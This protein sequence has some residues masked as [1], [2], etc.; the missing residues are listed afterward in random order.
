MKPLLIAAALLFAAPVA[1][2]P[3]AA[4]LFAAGKFSDAVTA[5]IAE[6]TPAS[7]VIAG[8]SQLQIAAYQTTDKAKARTLIA[9]ANTN[10][11]AALAKAPG[12]IDATLQ[13]IVAQGYVAK[14][15]QSS[16]GAKAMKK[17]LDAFLA[18]HPDNA[19]AWAVLGGWNGGAVASVG[20]FIAGTVLGAKL[21]NMTNAFDR[22]MALA[23]TDPAHPTFYALTLLDIDDDNA[24]QAKALL[25]R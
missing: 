5:G 19:V 2:A 21:G 9:A 25:T 22:A 15:D 13:K 14:L 24:A 16:G 23:P 17:A 4:G 10:F 12:N 11:D 7:L 18:A 3:N 20:K 8:R 6:A 1:A